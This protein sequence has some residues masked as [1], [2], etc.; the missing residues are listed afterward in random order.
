MRFRVWSA[1]SKRS[2]DETNAQ[3]FNFQRKEDILG[4]VFGKR[5][6]F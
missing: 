3:R 1:Q 4:G 5:N 2:E 6:V